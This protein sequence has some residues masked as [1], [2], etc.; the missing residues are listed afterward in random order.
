MESN[1]FVLHQ[2]LPTGD[3]MIRG[4]RWKDHMGLYK[5]RAENKLGQD[6]STTFLY[7]VVV[8][9]SYT[10]AFDDKWMMTKLL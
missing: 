10:N 8:Y 3:L 5:C 2:I 6:E 1:V 9:I 4:L 7:P